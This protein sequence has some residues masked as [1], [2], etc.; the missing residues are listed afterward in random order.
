FGS[1]HEDAAQ[2]RSTE[3][4]RRARTRIVARIASYETSP[5]F[6]SRKQQAVCATVSQTPPA[7]AVPKAAVRRTP[8]AR[9]IPAGRPAANRARRW[10][11]KEDE[12]ARSRNASSGL[13]SLARAEISAPPRALR[14]TGSSQ[15]S[16]RYN[17]RREPVTQ[18]SG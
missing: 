14:I 7:R 17:A 11:R 2:R 5:Y 9:P 1:E 13:A 18:T 6:L 12:P 8:A 16:S 3:Q 15:E 10:R 4:A